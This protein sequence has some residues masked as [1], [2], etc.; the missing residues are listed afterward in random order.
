[1]P[2]LGRLI[3]N[4]TDVEGFTF[5]RSARVVWEEA[6]SKQHRHHVDWRRLQL[7]A[8]IAVRKLGVM[9]RAGSS[10]H[11]RQKSETRCYGTFANERAVLS[12]HSSMIPDPPLKYFGRRAAPVRKAPQLYRSSASFVMTGSGVRIPLA[13]PIKSSTYLPA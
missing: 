4:P 2:T 13:A 11:S 10:P 6:D 9:K 8:A 7:S 5:V 12:N 1:M 3:A